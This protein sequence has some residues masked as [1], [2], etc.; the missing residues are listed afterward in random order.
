MTW[1]WSLVRSQPRLPEFKRPRHMPA[2]TLPD[3]SQ[4]KFRRAGHRRPGSGQ[5]WRGPAQGGSRGQRRRQACRYELRH[6]P[7]R[8]ASH[9]HVEGHGRP[10]DPAPLDRAPAREGRPGALPRRTGDDRSGHRGRLLLRL[11]LQAP[12]HAGGPRRDRKAHDARSLAKDLPV[13]RTRHGAGRGGR[14]L[15]ESRRALQ[16]GDHRERSPQTRQS[17][18]TARATGSTSAAVRTCHRPASSRRSS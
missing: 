18:S 2:I 11:R 3:G 4:K 5:H 7:R 9:R 1:W 12:V 13:H 17:A 6:R 14:L 8:E 15:Q 16:G 10:R